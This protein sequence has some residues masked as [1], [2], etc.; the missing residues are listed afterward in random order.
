MIPAPPTKSV[1][2]YI[3]EPTCSSRSA[4]QTAMESGVPADAVATWELTRHAWSLRVKGHAE[5]TRQI[6]A[7]S[8]KLV[9]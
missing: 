9:K 7:T 5:Y 3:D 4:W 1:P 2:T 6:D 8:C